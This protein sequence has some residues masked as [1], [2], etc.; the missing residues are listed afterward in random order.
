MF[1]DKLTVGLELVG[2][3]LVTHREMMDNQFLSSGDS[4][5]FDKFSDY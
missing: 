4:I 5:K 3:T 1:E 2:K